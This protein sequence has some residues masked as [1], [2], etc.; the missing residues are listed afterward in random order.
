MSLNLEW[1]ETV[2]LSAKELILFRAHSTNVSHDNQSWYLLK[3]IEYSCPYLH[4]TAGDTERR[5]HLRYY[6]TGIC[7][8]DTDSRGYCV[9]NGA[10]CAFAHGIHDLRNPVYDLREL[11]AMEGGNGGPNGPNHD[12]SGSGMMIPGH[13]HLSHHGSS[14]S[15][16]EGLNGPN[17]LD[18]ERNAL[19][20]DPRWQETAYVLSNYKT[21][22][23]KRPPRLCR[24]GLVL[25]TYFCSNWIS[26]TWCQLYQTH[27]IRLP[28]VPQFK[29]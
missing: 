5:Y 23:C 16:G 13:N 7:V 24:Q 3:F 26:L 25:D 20:E 29:G 2:A 11:Q 1:L 9:K 15:G 10:H 12:I 21:E 18:K 19:N 17:S 8:Y 27:Q 6:K 28:P 14:T 22:L 4:R